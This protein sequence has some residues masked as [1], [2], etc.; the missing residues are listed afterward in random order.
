MPATREAVE[1]ADAV[2]GGA[3]PPLLR[4][5]YL[6]VANGGFG[7]SYGVMGLNG[8]FTDDQG[9]TAVSLHERFSEEDP[10]DPTWS[11]DPSWLPFCYWGCEVYSVV[12]CKEPFPVFYFDPNFKR[13][14]RSMADIVIPHRETFG[15]WIKG[16]LAGDDMWGEVWG[17]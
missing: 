5:V 8:G 7:P 15:S 9:E 12:V 2:V 11:W 4:R 14:D 13:P 10:D 6:L 1:A 3:L 17:R 16:W